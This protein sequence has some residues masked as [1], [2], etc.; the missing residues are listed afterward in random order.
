MAALM[1]STSVEDAAPVELPAA[2]M[3]AGNTWKSAVPVKSARIAPVPM[4]PAV[5]SG[6]V[7]PAPATEKPVSA[8]V[9]KPAV[10]P[11]ADKQGPTTGYAIIS[12]S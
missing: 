12:D 1:P 8:P 4:V 9:A 2:N 6:R 7:V 11:G 3:A 5:S 10:S